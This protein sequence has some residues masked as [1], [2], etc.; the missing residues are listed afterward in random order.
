[1][2]TALGNFAAVPLV[3]DA[4]KEFAYSIVIAV[5]T[6]FSV[7]S[8]LYHT[9]PG[10]NVAY[11]YIRASYQNDPFRMLLELCLVA[12]L[13][14]Y[15]FHGRYRIRPGAN[16]VVLTEKEINE[17]CETWEPE[18]LVPSL[19]EFRRQELDKLPVLAGP[20]G[21]KV[22]MA[23]GKEKLN[24]GSY[25]F[26]GFLNSEAVKESAVKALRKY[27]VGTCGPRGFYGTIDVHLQLENELAKFLGTESAILYS[28]DFSTIASCIP[29]FC[30]RGD[31]IVADE[32][33]S[34]AIQKGLEISRSTV[35]FFK[36]NDM[37]DLERVLAELQKENA[38]K[39][40]SRRFLVVEG[41]YSQTANIVPLPQLIELKKKYKYR[42][43]VEET[44]SFGVLGKRGAG[45]SDHFDIDARE[46]DVIVAG[47]T[48]ALGS[49][50]GFVAG[51]QE[52][53]EHQ[54][55]SGQAYTYSASLPALLAVAASQALSMLIDQPETLTR[56]RQN[57]LTVKNI[58]KTVPN[59]EICGDEASPMFHLR[60]KNR[61]AD[62]LEEDRVLQEI[63]DQ[64]YKEGVLVSRAKH[65][66]SQDRQKPTLI[67]SIRICCSAGHTQK[68][69]ERSA[70]IIRDTWK[71]ITKAK[72]L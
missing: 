54:K 61:P 57:T 8:D 18:P 48:H 44:L 67:P 29:S 68:E 22:K 3:N 25:N 12:F 10:S 46:I 20:A 70:T 24:F 59:L 13:L 58:L 32:C 52:I 63:V 42:L 64:I 31:I 7:A 55:L 41:I 51:E 71:K 47:L 16:P 9:I 49:S 69:S 15:I 38:K 2:A 27:G 34:F 62:R 14:W 19:S 11:K 56:M 43:I 35:R 39:P 37:Q 21:T 28:Q 50:G 1:M 65:V 4:A 53:C 26:L 40:L 6:T 72:K 60:L 5:N 66:L 30:K 45:V 23:D 36:H 33:C 17:L